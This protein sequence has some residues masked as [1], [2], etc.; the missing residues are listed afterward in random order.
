[1]WAVENSVYLFMSLYGIFGINAAGKDTLCLRARELYPKITIVRSSKVFMQA[2]GFDDVDPLTDAVPTNDQYD[3][4]RSLSSEMT[5][6]IRNGYFQEYLRKL[7]GNRDIIAVA[8]FHLAHLKRDKGGN[9]FV[10]EEALETW[11]AD[12]LDGAVYVR[13]PIEDI[14]ARIEYDKKRTGRDRGGFSVEDI[15]RQLEVSDNQ[16]LRLTRDVLGNSIHTLQIDNTNPYDLGDKEA[17]NETITNS[18]QKLVDFV[19]INNK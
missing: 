9:V 3:A 18:A 14:E 2:L 13:T 6:Q 15:A 7:S 19:I 8:T 10:Q 16:W 1:M 17:V 12:V 5:E 11:M 4:L